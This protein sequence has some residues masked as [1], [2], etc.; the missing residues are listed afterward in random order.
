MERVLERLLRYVTFDTQSREKAD[1]FPSTEK[2][3]VLGR[4]LMEELTAMGAQNVRMM[5][6]YGYV[7]ADIPSNLPAGRKAPVIGFLAHLDTAPAVSGENVR[8]RVIRNYDGGDIPLNDEVTMTLQEFPEMADYAGKTLVVTDGTT[9]LGADDKAGVAEIMTMAERLLTHPE[10]PHGEIRLGFTLDEEVGRSADYFDVAAFGA[11]FAYTVDGGP[12]GMLDYENF[13]SANATVRVQGTNMNLGGAKNRMKNAITVAEEFD[14]LLP[15]AQRPEYTEK[16]E[17]YFHC[18]RFH[19]D[20]TGVVLEYFVRDHDREK[21]ARR[22]ALLQEAATFLNGKY[23][24]DTVQVEVQDA[25]FNMRDKLEPNW[26]LIENALSAMEELGITPIMTP[27]RGCTDGAKLS[28]MGLP[29]PNLCTGAYHYHT[30]YEFCCVESMEKTVDLLVRIVE[31]Y[32]A[33]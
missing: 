33:S 11:D 19:G 14:A 13:N 3:K 5:E 4:A 10:I 7:F 23:G 2:Q 16:Y 24:P 22:K 1:C 30:V 26:H 17:G 15:A 8:P 25:F 20:H 28:W 12:L 18:R 6:P 21:F 29:C 27:I 32:A 9:L 31:K